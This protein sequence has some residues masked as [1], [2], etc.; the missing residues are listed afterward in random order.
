MVVGDAGLILYPHPKSLDPSYAD[1]FVA[2]LAAVNGK[3][4]VDDQ[5]GKYLDHQ[6]ILSSGNQMVDSEVMFP[7][8]KDFPY[9]PSEPVNK[10][11]LL[12]C[13]GIATYSNPVFGAVD[14]VSHHSAEF[15]GL[16]DSSGT[17]QSY[18]IIEDVAVWIDFVAS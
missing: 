8:R 5:S 2:L 1:F 18:C 12:C 14:G 16:I 15:P 6:A 13:Q 17:Q 9:V 4:E 11:N 10:S 7:L 3:Q